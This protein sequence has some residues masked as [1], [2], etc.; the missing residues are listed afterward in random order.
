M[1]RP[2][3]IEGPGITLWNSITKDFD[4]EPYEYHLLA[5]AC[6]IRTAIDT[7]DAQ[8]EKDGLMLWSAQG[9]RVHPAVA[10]ARQQRI[11][12]ARFLKTLDLPP[13]SAG[14]DIPPKVGDIRVIPIIK[15]K[16]V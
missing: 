3:D 7:L 16:A 8:V 9:T 1:K 11:A 15:G 14:E 12:L 2:S 4:L 10:E 5:D 6:R 13:A